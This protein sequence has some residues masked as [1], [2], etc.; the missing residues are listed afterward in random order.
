MLWLGTTVVTHGLPILSNVVIDVGI[1]CI[2]CYGAR[3]Y[4]NGPSYVQKC[5]SGLQ[6][7]NSGSRGM[8]PLLR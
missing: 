6:A 2:V 8:S 4:K 3:G 5:F 7:A 1:S